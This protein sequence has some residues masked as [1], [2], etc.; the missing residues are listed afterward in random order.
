MLSEWCWRER[1]CTYK[2]QSLEQHQHSNFAF[3]HMVTSRQLTLLHKLKTLN[4]LKVKVCVCACKLV[5]LWVVFLLFFSQRGSRS[6]KWCAENT[7]SNWPNKLCVAAASLSNSCGDSLLDLLSNTPL[8][9]LESH[10]AEHISENK[11][12]HIPR[13]GFSVISNMI[14]INK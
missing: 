2:L 12:N 4:R 10:S 8:S 14:K 7:F 11:H 1:R 9:S 13:V 5:Y 6:Q 3:S